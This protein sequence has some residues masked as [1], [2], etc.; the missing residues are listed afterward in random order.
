MWTTLA[1]VVLAASS[2]PNV[3]PA[4][5]TVGQRVRLSA[6]PAVHVPGLYSGTRGRFTT[7]GAY[8]RRDGL[9]VFTRDD[10]S[11]EAVIAPGAVV[12]GVLV[13]ADP[14]FLHLRRADMEPAERIHRESVSRVE[15]FQ[16]RRG[17]A[18]MGAVIGGVAGGLLG[19]AAYHVFTVPTA[20]WP[21]ADSNAGGATLYC[22]A[23]GL[24]VGA[25]LGALDRH[26][27][28]GEVP[29][30]AL[31]GRRLELPETAR[32]LRPA[33]GEERGPSPSHRSWAVV[34]VRGGSLAS[35][36]VPAGKRLEAS[37]SES[38]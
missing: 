1:L 2:S 18:G 19:L 14:T 20:D 35:A 33:G 17:R 30:E 12:T 7:R 38:E 22:G 27:D 16:G 36:V 32:A 4:G 8:E 34:G 28:W 37:P 9:L 26:D 5:V 29:L 25:G 15:A 13:G 31:P 3:P 21:R 23:M 24:A 10:G 11:V 6:G